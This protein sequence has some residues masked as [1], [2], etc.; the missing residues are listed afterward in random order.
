MKVRLRLLVALAAL[1][2]L[3]VAAPTANAQTPTPKFAKKVA[4]SGKSKSGRSFKGTYTID[5][6][7]KARKGRYAGQLVAVGTVRGKSGN[8]RYVKSGVVLP[9][10]LTPASGSA[11]LPN[12]P[13][14]C[15]VLNLRLGPINLNLLGLVVR[16]NRINLRIDAIPSG[17]PGGGLLGDL[18]CGISNLLNSSGLSPNQVAALLNSLLALLQ[19]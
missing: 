7:T 5:R 16:T 1:A 18:L 2:A 12:I 11:Q 13:G 3:V 15:Q 17:M 4:L 10:K 14:A 19:F 8:K 6:F 9:A